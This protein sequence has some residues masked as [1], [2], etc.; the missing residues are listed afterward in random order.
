VDTVEGVLPTILAAAR[1][2]ATTPK[3]VE[4]TEKL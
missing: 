2:D 4:I 3:D 1:P